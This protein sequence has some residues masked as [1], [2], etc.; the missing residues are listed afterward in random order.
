MKEDVNLQKLYYDDDYIANYQ[1]IES[2]I[3]C[4]MGSGE[5]R[6]IPWSVESEL[7][8]LEVMK[9]QAIYFKTK[10]SKLK[11]SRNFEVFLGASQVLFAGVVANAGSVAMQ[12]G[13]NLMGYVAFAT[14]SIFSLSSIASGLKINNYNKTTKDINKNL[15]YLDNEQDYEMNEIN[16]EYLKTNLSKKGQLQLE[17][18][19]QENGLDINKID[20]YSFEDLKNLHNN[21]KFYCEYSDNKIK[22]KQKTLC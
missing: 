16:L 21:L 6:I 11:G 14:A 7:K 13:D 2:N 8:I 1:V 17:M 20:G 9:T 5:N 10:L 15:Y 12:N 22:S 19:W 3:V 4:K 18:D